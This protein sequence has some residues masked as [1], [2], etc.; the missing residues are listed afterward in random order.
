MSDT[1]EQSY[2]I[3]NP[4]NY[5]EYTFAPWKVK[6]DE[7]IIKF[8]NPNN[9]LRLA[10]LY[11]LNDDNQYH[12]EIKRNYIEAQSEEEGVLV[13]KSLMAVCEELVFQSK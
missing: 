5:G 12:T 1:N 3:P 9:G 4:H 11:E 13:I 10:I 2:E 8:L 6:V 7:N